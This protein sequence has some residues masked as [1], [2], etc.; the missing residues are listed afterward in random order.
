MKFCLKIVDVELTVFRLA[1]VL[2]VGVLECS[3][4]GSYEKVRK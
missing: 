3:G 1:V 2:M 4:C